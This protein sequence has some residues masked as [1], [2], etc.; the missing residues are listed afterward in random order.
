M[1]QPQDQDPRNLHDLA[2]DA[3]TDI[4][5]LAVGL[6]HAGAAPQ[7]VAQLT[8]MG[9][10]L[11]Q[12]VKVLANGP[13]LGTGASPAGAPQGG[14]PQGQPPG[15]P[16]AAPGGPPPGAPPAPEPPVH[17]SLQAASQHLHSAMVAS[18]QQRTGPG[19]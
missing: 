19:Q 9:Q 4:Q 15:P 10:I 11:S 5:K 12:V 13:D 16:Q 8:H 18:A 3:Q 6:A 2:L 1:A 7:A 14:P 17:Q